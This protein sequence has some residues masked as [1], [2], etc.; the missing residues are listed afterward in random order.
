MAAKGVRIAPAQAA[1]PPAMRRR[2]RQSRARAS[3]QALQEAFVRVLLDGG[4]EKTTVREVVAVAG[5]GVGTFYEYFGNMPALAALVVHQHVK[6]LAQQAR[7]AAR[8]TAGQPLAQVV[9]AQ[10][11][12]QVA[13]VLG[14]AVLWARLFALER[15]VSPPEAFARQYEA[16]VELWR[17]ALAAAHDAPRDAPAAARM[18]HSMV[19]YGSVSQALLSRGAAGGQGAAGALLRAE[20]ERAAQAYAAALPRN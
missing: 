4:C 6:A 9:A 13:P 7:A 12:A 20:L 5:V 18:L 19:A 15:Q 11:H 16:W 14:Q 3:S 17:A 8:R 2:P 1:T 10:L